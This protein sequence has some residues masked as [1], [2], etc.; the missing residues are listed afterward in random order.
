MSEVPEINFILDCHQPHSEVMELATKTVWQSRLPMTGEALERLSLPAGFIKVGI[1]VAVM[2]VHYFRCSPGSE[3]DSPVT[4]REIAGHQFI[5]CANSPAQGAETPV[6]GGPQL[7]KVDKHH[8]LVFMPGR[9]VDVLCLPDGKKYVQVISA[10]PEGD[11]I[12]Q[13]GLSPTNDFLLPEGWSLRTMTFEVRTTIHLPNPTE[14][15]FFDNGAS[16]QG[17]VE[18]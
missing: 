3:G 10:S 7:L 12:M 17:P 13:R 14:A 18:I 8:S 16:F 2:D 9:T 4:E 6:P 1:G 11:G 15:W 5:H